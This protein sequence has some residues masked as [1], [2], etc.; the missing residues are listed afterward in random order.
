MK[1]NAFSAGLLA[2][3][4][5]VA[6]CSL[7]PRLHAQSQSPYAS[8]QQPRGQEQPEQQKG[9]TFVGQIVKAKNGQYALLTDKD[10]GKGFYLDNQQKAGQFFGQNVKVTGTLDVATNTIHVA[11]IQPA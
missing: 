4:L 5:A 8:S 3:L 11:D 9:E 7:T 2:L 10:S 6:F 1:R